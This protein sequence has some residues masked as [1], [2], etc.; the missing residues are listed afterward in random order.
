MPDSFVV[1]A[2]VMAKWFNTGEVNEEDA[3]KL[4][5]AWIDGRVEL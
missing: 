3:L 1:D 4:R 5:S 2:S